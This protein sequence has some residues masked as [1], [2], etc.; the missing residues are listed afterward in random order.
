MRARAELKGLPHRFSV[1]QV[2]A[3]A[4][5]PHECGGK[6]G[7]KGATTEL[8]YEYA[9]QAGLVQEDAAADTRYPLGGG[10][11]E[12]PSDMA[13]SGS[14]GESSKARTTADGHEEHVAGELAASLRNGRN[15]GMV[16][17][18]KLPENRMEPIIRALMESGPLTV[19]VAAS[20]WWHYYTEGIMTGDDCDENNVIGHA[21]VLFGIGKED[22][23][24]VGQVRFWHLKNS[25]GNSWGEDGNIRIEKTSSEEERCGWDHKPGSGSG[26]AGGPEKVWVCG[27]CAILYNAAMPLF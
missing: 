2:V 12:C 7:C 13:M 1:G 15:T 23:E 4:P 22:V 10:Q 14:E 18:T 3:C 9:L 6:G 8:A 21:V 27:S 25:W 26:C 20:R 24:G 11:P 5:N 17:W 19:S 16:G